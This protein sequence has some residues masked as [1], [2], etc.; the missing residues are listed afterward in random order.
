MSTSFLCSTNGCVFAI[1]IIEHSNKLSIFLTQISATHMMPQHVYSSLPCTTWQCYCVSRQS[2]KQIT[3]AGRLHTK[4]KETASELA[5]GNAN[6]HEATCV[7]VQNVSA[8]GK[9]LHVSWRC[10]HLLHKCTGMTEKR[11]ERG[12]KCSFSAQLNSQLEERNCLAYS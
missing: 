12:E 3:D 6:C 9:K 1:V 10:M 8:R 4:S 11:K 2:A 5:H 7:Q